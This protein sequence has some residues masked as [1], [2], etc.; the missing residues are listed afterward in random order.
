MQNIIQIC[1]AHPDIRIAWYHN[2]SLD[3]SPPACMALKISKGGEVVYMD[4]VDGNV[5]E[6]DYSNKDFLGIV[7]SSDFEEIK[8]LREQCETRYEKEIDGKSK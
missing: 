2:G 1:Q 7:L 3:L 8:K 6:L 4:T 5:E